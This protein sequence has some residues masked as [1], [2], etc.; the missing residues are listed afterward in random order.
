MS[1]A[2]TWLENGRWVRMADVPERYRA[3][4]SVQFSHPLL[5]RCALDY[6]P[7]KGPG[8]SFRHEF[9]LTPDGVLA[10]LRSDDAKQFGATWPLLENDGTRLR[11][12]CS[13]R[14]ASTAYAAGADQQNFLA[15]DPHT[16]VS[17]ADEPVRSA[18][19]WLRPVRAVTAGGVNHTF[20]YARN[21]TD[22]PPERV[23]QGFRL[24]KDGF[25]SEL[26]TVRATTYVGR[27]SAG[28]EG[29]SIACNRDGTADATFDPSCRFVLQLDGGKI[30]AVEVD[31][32]VSA[33]IRG[34]PFRLEA[35]VP[36]RIAP[37]LARNE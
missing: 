20:V 1:F 9:V 31:R 28:G 23:Q 12:S 15:L 8:P 37:P 16:Q 24:T 22:P 2:P 29:A 25:E 17:D 13:D 30:V 32:K 3:R 33:T 6:R 19:G 14:G 18:Y 34:K 4:F 35:L 26:G 11:T 21:A 5:V 7:V 10:T 36:L 27:T